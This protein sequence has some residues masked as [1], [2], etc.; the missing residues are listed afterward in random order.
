MP[1]I[2]F[3]ALSYHFLLRNTWNPQGVQLVADVVLHYAVP[4]TYVIY[5]GVESATR[6]LRWSEPLA[7]SVY[8]T[9]YLIYALIRGSVVGSY[10]Y[11][12]IDSVRLG[13]NRPHPR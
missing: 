1:N 6:L 8:P 2:A 4:V 7:W 3:V 9:V 11:P 10:P 13:Y 12:F 5:W